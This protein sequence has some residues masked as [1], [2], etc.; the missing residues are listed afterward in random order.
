MLWRMYFLM[1]VTILV[2]STAASP[3]HSQD[4][5]RKIPIL[6]D[7][8]ILGVVSVGQAEQAE[9]L[10]IIRPV[11]L[12]EGETTSLSEDQLT[13]TLYKIGPSTDGARCFQNFNLI[14]ELARG[15]NSLNLRPLGDRVLI[16][17]REENFDPC[18]HGWTRIGAI[19][20]GPRVFHFELGTDDEAASG[21]AQI[22][23]LLVS[24]IG[25]NGETRTQGRVLTVS[26]SIFVGNVAIGGEGF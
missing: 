19:V 3:G 11:I 25:P 9:M 7:I 6:G 8:P 24:V 5:P 16:N 13:I 14:D 1:A 2:V 10:I 15:I 26:P 18:F 20:S 21:A 23:P 17:G 22:T 4:G 12:A